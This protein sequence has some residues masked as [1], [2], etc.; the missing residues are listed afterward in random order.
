[1]PA[2]RAWLWLVG[3]VAGAASTFAASGLEA[4]ALAACTAV[5][6]EAARPLIPLVLLHDLSGLLVAP[7]TEVLRHG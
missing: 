1:V 5:A 2:L 7:V 6:F 4:G 3:A